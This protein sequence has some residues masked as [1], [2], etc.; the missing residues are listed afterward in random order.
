MEV[1]KKIA[2]IPNVITRTYEAEVKVINENSSDAKVGALTD[3]NFIVG[4]YSGVKVPLKALFLSRS[5]FLYTVEEE[6]VRKME[7]EIEDII[8]DEVYI[9]GLNEGD[10]VVISG[11]KRIQDGETVTVY[12]E[13][14]EDAGTN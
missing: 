8:D 14:V 12:D 13:V 1:W 11:M 4:Q 3:V 2:Q 6:T 9:S 7:V 10:R 5:T